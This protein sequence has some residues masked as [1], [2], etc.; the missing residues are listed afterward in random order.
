MLQS[1]VEQAQRSRMYL[2]YIEGF[3]VWLSCLSTDGWRN[4]G[5]F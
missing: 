2:D 3:T 1:K 4:L 5:C